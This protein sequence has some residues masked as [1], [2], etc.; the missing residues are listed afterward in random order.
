M[1][2]IL[3]NTEVAPLR[4]ELKI[5]VPVPAVEAAK[6]RVVQEIRRRAKLPGFRPGKVPREVV[7]RRYREDIEREVIER[8]VPDFWHQAQHEANL[9]PLMQP[10]VKDVEF[11]AGQPGSFVATVEVRPE[12]ELRNLK[13]F[14]L[15]PVEVEPAREEV[16]EALAQLQRSHADWQVVERAASRG[17]L[18]LGALVELDAAT[19]EPVGEAPQPV[20]FE[21]GDGHV[22]EEL[23]LA[24]T[25][26]LAGREVDF[27]RTAAAG[28]PSAEGSEG[29]GSKKY[30]LKLDSVREADLP[31]LDD[32]FAKKLGVD[33]LAALRSEVEAQ[34]RRS[35]AAANRQQRE[36]ALLEQLCERHPTPLPQWVVEGEIRSLLQDH[37][38]DLGRR[39]VDLENAGLDWNQL[40]E[41][42]RPAAERRVHARLVLDAVAR[43]E[44]LKV[45]EQELAFALSTL[46][47]M[48]GKSPAV[49][50][51]ELEEAGKL[52]ALAAQL[53]RERAI[54]HLLGETPPPSIG[55]EPVAEASE[56]AEPA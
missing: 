28:P 6:E 50:G 55:E 5:E 51:R 8:L 48:Q 40:A 24:A 54:R 12:I 23:S 9:E 25:G 53:R 30:R 4:R 52:G 7:E 43:Q 36:Q 11:A 49:L 20:Q 56:E 37:A 21:V 3:S 31:A 46:A 18:V 47:R 16:D 44:G 35:K 27:E 29:A 17:D 32:D 2:V 34:L 42:A 1:S 33:D 13:D 10:Q 39:G 45:S 41:Q 19:G 38:E 26:V 15:P 14:A 22:W